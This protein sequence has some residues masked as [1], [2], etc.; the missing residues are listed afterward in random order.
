M[1]ETLEVIDLGRRGYLETLELQRALRLERLDGRQPNDI[2]L[3]VEHEPTYTLGRGTRTSSLPVSPD[4][5][6]SRGATVVEIE[7]GGDVTWHGP[8]QLVGYPIVSLRERGL[9][10][11]HRLKCTRRRRRPAHVRAPARPAASLLQG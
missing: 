11:V 7:R 3:L 8:G 4:V 5:L 1:N 9:L 6:R 10:Q 2:L